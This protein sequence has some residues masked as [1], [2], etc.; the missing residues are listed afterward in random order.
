MEYE[1]E[2]EITHHHLTLLENARVHWQDDEYGAPEI[3]PKRPYGNSRV[4]EDLA[5][6]LP[7]CDPQEAAQIHRETEKALEICL[8]TQEFRMGKFGRPQDSFWRQIG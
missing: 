7:E 1:E 5:K 2:F 8:R 4:E 6:L 3:D